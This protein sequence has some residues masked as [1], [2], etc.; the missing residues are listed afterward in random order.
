MS[1]TYKVQIKSGKDVVIFQ[2]SAP[3]TESRTANY[4]GHDI[5]HLPTDIF[6]YKNTTNRTFAITAKIVS[7]NALE[8]QANSRYI[9]LIRSWVLPDFGN[10]G[11]TPPIVM[12][13]AFY[14]TNITNVPCVLHTYSLN[15][16]EDV[17]WVYT[18]A[19][20]N[21]SFGKNS[22]YVGNNVGSSAMPVIMSITID[23]NEAYTA[24]QI[25]NKA[26][27]INRS[28][29][30]SFVL[31]GAADDVTSAGG[32]Q[33][34][35]GEGVTPSI[36]DITSDANF[37]G[38]ASSQYAPVQASTT[39]AGNGNNSKTFGVTPSASITNTTPKNIA[40]L[41]FNPDTGEFQAPQNITD[42]K[43][44]PTT[45]Q[46]E[47]FN[48]NTLPNEPPTLLQDAFSTF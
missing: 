42:K 14:N 43:F 35:L 16:P 8:A 26:W 3:I 9:D 30:G 28:K 39:N 19:S 34:Q 17:D 45:G 29:G 4:V 7:R 20:L 24:Q 18:G 46:F 11:A 48:R 33:A 32:G 25:T 36:L 2:A 37:T 47:P 31:G 38:I 5:V 21:K 40:N 41:R 44:N 15:F 23:L 1:T 13:S 12:L 10:S 6:A 22:P 27:K